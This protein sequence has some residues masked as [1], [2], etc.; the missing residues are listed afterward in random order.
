MNQDG[1]CKTINFEIHQ[2]KKDFKNKKIKLDEC[3]KLL[4]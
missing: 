1:G 4:L 2:L 3:N